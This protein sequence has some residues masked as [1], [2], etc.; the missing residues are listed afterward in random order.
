[1]RFQVG[2]REEGVDGVEPALLDC[3]G[4]IRN[5]TAVAARLGSGIEAADDEIIEAATRVSR[6]FSES[7]PLHEADEE[8]SLRPR[9]AGRSSEVDAALD[10][11]TTQHGELHPLVDELV[12]ITAAVAA[13]P[14][15]RADPALMERL[16]EVVAV[17]EGMWDRHLD[18]E[19]SVL[20]PAVTALDD[21]TQTEIRA[22]MRARR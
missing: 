11:M 18:L 22:E 7:L 3:H 9:L 2:R 5:L 15:R 8:E 4:R 12:E 17:L 1:M 13:D 21:A 19:E 6:Y 14:R 16:A 10:A 20:F